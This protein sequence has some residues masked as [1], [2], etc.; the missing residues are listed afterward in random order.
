MSRVILPAARELAAQLAHR[1]EQDTQLARRQADAQQQ[2]TRANDRLWSGLHPDGLAAVYGE[3]PAAVD[4]A[5]AN[6]HSEVLAA[7]DP[8]AAVGQVHWCVRQA[9]IEHQAAAEERRQLAAVTGELIRQLID[10]LAVAGWSEER[11]RDAD[12]H[13]FATP[14]RELS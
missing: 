4:F 7:P 10:A 14:H 1:F 13:E 8:L 2:L 5:V 11:A 3:D 9:F 12:V 6:H